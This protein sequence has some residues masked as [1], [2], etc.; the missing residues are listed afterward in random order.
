MAI[1]AREGKEE[2]LLETVVR[3]GGTLFHLTH[4]YLGLGRVMEVKGS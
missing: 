3:I 4:T 2:Y 1:M